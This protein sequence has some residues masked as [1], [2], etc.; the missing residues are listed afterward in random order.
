MSLAP[1]CFT[2]LESV[3]LK[4]IK[5]IKRKGNVNRKK[6]HQLSLSSTKLNPKVNP[7]KRHNNK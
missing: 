1:F 5:T 7:Y 2:T 4:N 3:L 6:R